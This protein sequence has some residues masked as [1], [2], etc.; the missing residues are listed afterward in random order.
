[1]GIPGAIPGIRSHESPIKVSSRCH[2]SLMKGA[3]L[4]GN[5]KLFYSRLS[6]ISLIGITSEKG[7]NSNILGGM[8]NKKERPGGGAQK[9]YSGNVH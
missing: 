7:V 4:K 5:D 9:F 6:S 2:Q 8:T 1:M 3:F